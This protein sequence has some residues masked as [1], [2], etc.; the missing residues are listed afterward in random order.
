ML[1]FESKN[2]NLFSK[3]AASDLTTR[4]L[5]EVNSV[6][7]VNFGIPKYRKRTWT[8]VEENYPMLVVKKEVTHKVVNV[9][10]G[11]RIGF[12]DNIIQLWKVMKA[13]PKYVVVDIA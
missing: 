9:G 4:V 5:E 2:I 3:Y 11:V 1:S 13:E 10:R 12:A 7:E 8:T 6:D